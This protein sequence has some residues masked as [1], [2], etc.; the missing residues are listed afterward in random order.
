MASDRLRHL[1]QVGKIGRHDIDL[2]EA[3]PIIE[4]KLSRAHLRQ[5]TSSGRSSVG[6]A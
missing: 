5:S 2:A 6:P 1:R 3:L 4:D